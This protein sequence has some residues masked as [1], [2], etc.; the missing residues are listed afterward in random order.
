MPIRRKEEVAAPFDYDEALSALV[1]AMGGLHISRIDEMPRVDLYRDQVL[2][3]VSMELAPLYAAGERIVTGSMVNN[4]VKQRVIPAPA[5]KRYTSRHLAYLLFVCTFKR[6]LSIAQV[7]QLL[8]MCEEAGLDF[9]EV[10]DAMVDALERTLAARFAKGDNRPEDVACPLR[11][12]DSGG[13]DVTGTLPA[14][15]ESAIWLVANEVYLD[16]MLVLE[17]RRTRTA[18][19]HELPDGGAE[20]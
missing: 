5:R 3:I 18:D 14:L 1:A 9:A 11:L 2:S 12:T 10:Y 19:V 7:S 8:V 6:V 13:A 17:E 4:Y 15:L 20:A 16:K